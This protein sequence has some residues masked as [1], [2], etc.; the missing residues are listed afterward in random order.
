MYTLIHDQGMIV[1]FV[2]EKRT[3]DTKQKNI[4]SVSEWL[5]INLRE[6][7]GSEDVR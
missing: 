4:K 2:K 3:I 7:E 5:S 6:A 1:Y